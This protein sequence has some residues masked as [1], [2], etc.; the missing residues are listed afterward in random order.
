MNKYENQIQLLNSADINVHGIIENYGKPFFIIELPNFAGIYVIQHVKEVVDMFKKN[1]FQTITK[2]SKQKID[3]FIDNS[4]MCIGNIEKSKPMYFGKF[5][6]KDDII[7][8]MTLI[9]DD[10]FRAIIN[11]CRDADAC[12]NDML[13][14]IKQVYEYRECT[15]EKGKFGLVAG[16]GFPGEACAYA[17]V[18]TFAYDNNG[19]PTTDGLRG[20]NIVIVYEEVH[21]YMEGYSVMRYEI[22]YDI[23][24]TL[25]SNKI[26]SSINEVVKNIKN[27]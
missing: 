14:R 27:R 23:L 11:I 20:E 6:F 18:K 4:V 17:I 1:A 21:S 3:H 19:L 13:C 12:F 26:L 24:Q 22:P 7:D 5:I 9:P 25:T 15:K 2:L 8:N 16:F 10:K